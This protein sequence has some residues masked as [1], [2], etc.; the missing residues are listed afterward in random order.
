MAAVRGNA[1]PDRAAADTHGIDGPWRSSSGIRPRRARQEEVL[2]K[3]R[4]IGQ[5]RRC[6]CGSQTVGGAPYEN[7]FALSANSG[8]GVR[9]APCLKSTRRFRLKWVA[10]VARFLMLMGLAVFFAG[11]VWAQ[12][13]GNISGTVRDTSGGL[14]P[15]ASVVIRNTAT[16]IK[17]TTKSD[18]AGFY[19][20]PSVAVGQYE[21]DVTHIG[22]RPYK[23]TAI[24]IDV[25]AKLKADVGLE[26][27]AVTEQVTVQANVLQ[28][29]TESTQMG[30]VITGRVITAVGLNG[31]SYTD[32]LALQPGIVPMSTQT[33]DSIVMAGV[34]VAIVPSGNLNP[35]NQSIS[36][37]REDANG[38]LVNGSDVKEEMNGGTSIIPNLDS[39]SE[40]RVLTNN[41]DA[42]LGN[43]SGGIVNVVTKGGTNHIHGNAFDFLRNTALD[44]R[45]YFSPDRETYQ[46]NQFGG[47]LGGPIEKDKLFFFGD[48]QG[49]RTKQGLD[50]GLITVPSLADRTGNLADMASSFSTAS[51][52]ETVSGAGLA[53]QLQNSLGYPVSQGEPYYRPGCASSSHCVFPNATIPKAAWTAPSQNLLQYIP[54]PNESSTTFAGQ[55]PEIIRDDKF[56]FRIDKSDMRWGNLSAYYF[57]DDY[58][59]NNPFPNSQ[60]GATVPGFGGLNHGRA[61][62]VSLGDS[63]TFAANTVNEVH[64]SF[65]RNSN[66]VGQPSGGLGVSLASQGFV[67][68]AGTA[69]ILPLAPQIEGVEN[70]V[71]QGQFVMGLPIT[72]LAQTNNT[73][74]IN[75]SLS[76]I[77]G[78]HDLKFGFILSFEQV[79]VN[80]DAIFNG[81]FVFDGYQTGSNFA[82]FLVGAPSQFS[83]QDSSRYYPRH[84]YA[85]WYAQ[86]AW[87]VR[88]NI[89]FNC[90]LRM[91][92]M[93]YWSEKY[94]QVPTFILGE[95]SVVYPNAFPGLV[96]P[97]DP[98]VPSTLVP[99]RFRY[100]PRVGIAYSPNQSSGLL[101]KVLGG[102]AKTSIRAS[103]GIFNTVIQGNTIGVDEPQPPYGL[104]DTVYNPLFAAPY[105][106]ADGTLGITPY[107]LTFPPLNARASHPNT[108]VI[109]DG[110][111]N[112]Q[113]G[114]TA[115]IPADTY[116]YTENYFLSIERQLPGQTV[117]NVS[118]VGSESHHQL[119][120]YSANP[121]NPAL[122]L[123]L[124]QPGVLAGGESCGPGDENN[125]FNLA[126]AFT[127]NGVNY[128][129]GATLQGTRMGLN[130]SLIN[131]N[132]I[133]NFYGNNDYIGSIGNS[134]YNALEVSVKASTKRLTYSLGYT[135]SKS[136]DQASSLADAVDPFNH[137]L[138]R[139]I[140]AWNLTHDFVTTYDYRLPL[141]QL[142]HHARHLL[143]GWE[144]SGVTRVTSGFPVTLSTNGDNSLEGSSPNGVNNRYLDLPDFTGERLDITNP[145]R[146]G[147]QDFNPSAFTDNAIG[148]VGDAPRR[149][150]S[151]PGGFNTDLVLRRNFE[152][153]ETKALQFRLESFNVFN[154]TQFFGPAAVSGDV[155]N[156]L[157]GHVVN[158]ASPRLIQ[159]ALKFAF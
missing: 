114:M 56:G 88:P 93:R 76:R 153:G 64:F 61:Q 99:E 108:S 126:E 2:Q 28:I 141:E 90:G 35:G 152:I 154:H 41:F 83:Q 135:Y 117:L 17:Q 85:G 106:L 44:S 140:S 34:T 128:P 57:F 120:V 60:G 65:M 123:A 53:A 24:T 22:F 58:F 36:G 98:G 7:C 155:D 26:I 146:N 81:T 3:S 104:S 86:D 95:Q 158:A 54:P 12:T 40:F 55:E 10:T 118:Y 115:P 33:P 62:L 107:P 91:E 37:Q 134:N 72:N 63:K 51:G 5:F 101:G 159:L 32:L 105:N 23:Q 77:V 138:T 121:G 142:T 144:I 75:D 50:T 110:V 156:Q 38:F 112:P 18:A 13:A 16:G 46:Q 87:P 131:N 1:G 19:A 6:W 49:T 100:A 11:A 137:N 82:D 15:D 69:G 48:Y 102:P 79:N 59:L 42:E 97:T 66:V 43:Y 70:I 21:L 31:R 92:L 143:E 139:A 74:T 14:V 133:G 29:E 30:D 67:T 96:Y 89:T 113:S 116:P 9:S 103:Y 109:F 127:F 147:L 39:I 151:G 68:G 136:I 149:Y 8:M 25:N 52:P 111:Y 122:C 148:T 150:F 84:R 129:A 130:T 4:N 47:T 94:D 73:F 124:N 145:H 119:L 71:F 157:F 80:P 45:N 78:A 132:A 125:E 27:G 20:F